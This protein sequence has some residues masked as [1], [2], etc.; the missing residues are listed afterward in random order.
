M[1]VLIIVKLFF[2]IKIIFSYFD[3]FARIKFAGLKDES[4]LDKSNGFHFVLVFILKLV[5]ISSDSKYNCSRR[6]MP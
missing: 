4:R 6:F 5:Y 1:F 2:E 3:L